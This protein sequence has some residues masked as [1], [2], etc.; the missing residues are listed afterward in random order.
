MLVTVFKCA[1]VVSVISYIPSP[2]GTTVNLRM[3]DLHRLEIL[4]LYKRLT[5][6]HTLFTVILIE[7]WLNQ[8]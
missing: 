6:T 3:Y 8:I 5:H 7:H 1:Y 4:G 2:G